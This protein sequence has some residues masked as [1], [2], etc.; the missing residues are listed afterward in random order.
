[1]LFGLGLTSQDCWQGG[2]PASSLLQTAPG[3]LSNIEAARWHRITSHSSSPS[4]GFMVE[5][6]A[7][8]SA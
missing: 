1:M 4:P 3:P 7:Q 2:G 6:S 8:P 5:S